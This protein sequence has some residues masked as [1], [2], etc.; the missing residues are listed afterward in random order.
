MNIK[1]LAVLLIAVLPTFVVAE[2]SKQNSDP[3]PATVTE[4]TLGHHMQNRDPNAESDAAPEHVMRNANPATEVKKT[5]VKK[6]ISTNA[7]ALEDPKK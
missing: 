3:N 7:A 4:P 1:L 6:R 5:E 2:P